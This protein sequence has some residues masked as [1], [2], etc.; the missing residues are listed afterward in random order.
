M[1]RPETKAEEVIEAIGPLPDWT[2]K[3]VKAAIRRIEKTDLPASQHIILRRLALDPRM[4]K[5]WVELLKK[6]RPT[7][8]YAY[9]ASKQ[10]APQ[11]RSRNRLQNE[12]LGEILNLTFSAARDGISVTKFAEVSQNKKLLLK[13]I[14]MLRALA[15]DLQ[16]ARQNGQFGLT[17]AVS[18][19]LAANDIAS[20]LKVAEWLDK[21]V[22]ALRKANDPLMVRRHRADP[23]VR[24]L[25][26]MIAELFLAIFGKRLDRT[27]ARLASVALDAKASASSARSTLTRKST[28]KR[29]ARTA[30]E[31]L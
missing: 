23:H 19:E 18:K 5:V 3:S 22:S 11:I 28:K 12:A 7:G 2:P 31:A 16:L 17:S 1:N 27:A 21:V 26:T 9:P 10:R 29:K 30:R 8:Q 4:G 15:N 14:S 25:Q 24:G 6:D 20:L 13:N